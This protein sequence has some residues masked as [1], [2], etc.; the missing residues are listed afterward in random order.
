[1]HVL[2]CVALIVKPKSW[3]VGQLTKV[4]IKVRS[5]GKAKAG[6]RVRLTGAGIN[7]TSKASNK[8]GVIVMR[9]K[10]TRKG[11]V[12]FSPMNHSACALVRV[13]VT[14]PNP[15]VTG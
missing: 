12:R 1:L 6:V 7:L 3:L 9:I 5:A 14:P 10:A 4:T 8:R 11:A 15:P 13:G 2:P